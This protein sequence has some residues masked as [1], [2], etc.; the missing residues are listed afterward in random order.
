M[1]KF[2]RGFPHYNKLLWFY[3]KRKKESIEALLHAREIH[4][5][6]KIILAGCLSE[7]YAKELSEEMSEAD[8]FMGNGD[9]SEIKKS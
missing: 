7:R 5:D 6:K 9:L 4:P 8:F 3:R 2:N 1:W